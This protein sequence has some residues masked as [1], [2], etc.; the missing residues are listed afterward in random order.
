MLPR[1]GRGLLRVDESP[2][3]FHNRRR[4]T[5][6][7]LHQQPRTHDNGQPRLPP[8]AATAAAQPQEAECHWH[9]ASERRWRRMHAVCL[10]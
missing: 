5:P 1:R 3:A 8:P 2:N 9:P 4:F 7:E 10:A 6:L